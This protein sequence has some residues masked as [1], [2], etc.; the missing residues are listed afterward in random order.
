MTHDQIIDLLGAYALDAVDDDERDAVEVHL[1]TCPRCRAEIE[2]HRE[3]AS[4]LA[5]PG[6]DAPV[7]LWDR[8]AGSLDDAPP[9]LA[10]VPR[11]VRRRW[12]MPATAVAVAAA[13]LVAVLGVELRDQNRRIDRLQAAVAEPMATTF[14]RALADPASHVVQ[15]SG[16]A[17]LQAVVTST[18]TGYLDASSLPRVASDRTYQLWGKVGDDLVSLGVLGNDPTIVSFGARSVRQ[19]AITDEAAGGVVRTTHQP[20]ASGAIS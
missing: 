5:H 15:L 17:R 11:P 3:V 4:L 6:S 8:I 20:L 10:L 2:E 14:A 16:S 19:L 9:P 18:G 1:L 7:G 13:V 12:W